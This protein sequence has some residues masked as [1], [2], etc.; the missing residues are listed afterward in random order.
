[1][2]AGNGGNAR[3]SA[4]GSLVDAQRLYD[5]GGVAAIVARDEHLALR[6]AQVPRGTH[7]DRADADTGWIEAVMD[8]IVFLVVGCGRVLRGFSRVVV[9]M[10][11]MTGDGGRAQGHGR[12][13]GL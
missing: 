11:M 8:W 12:L 1:M 7:G 2:F 3:G 10:M 13:D 4:G 5:G 9:M 6:P